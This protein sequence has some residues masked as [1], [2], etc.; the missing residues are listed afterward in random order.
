MGAYGGAYGGGAYGY[1]AY[2][3]MAYGGKEGEDGDWPNELAGLLEEGWEAAKKNNYGYII[4][5]WS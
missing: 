5:D 3:G 2:G 4:I 1:G